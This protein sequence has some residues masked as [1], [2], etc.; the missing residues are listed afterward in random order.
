MKI[1]NL[2]SIAFK[3]LKEDDPLIFFCRVGRFL[4]YQC[5][6]YL[7]YFLSWKLLRL[8]LKNRYIEK[9]IMG[10][11]MFLD[12]K[13]DMG[14]SYDLFRIGFREPF[15]TKAFHEE[16]SRGDVVVDIGA[17]IGY[18]VLLEA[19][20]VGKEGRVYAI[21]PVPQN[22]DLLKK[23]IKLN[24][25]SNVEVFQLAIGNENKKDL[26][27]L[28]SK[29]NCG[30]MIK[31]AVMSTYKDEMLVKVVSLDKF[32][33]N[34]PFPDLIR[35]DVEGYEIKIIRGMKKILES[36]KPLKIFVEIHPNIMK[37]KTKDFL[38][39]LKNFGFQAKKSNP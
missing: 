15:A 29:R 8:R 3:R 16:L 18:Y 12:V 14:I 39:I 32:L 38:N 23:N 13:E 2:V 27:Y 4:I 28:S 1:R 19:M 31:K 7:K 33:E 9:E 24:N 25:Y 36:N 34:K 11:R 26:I 22:V 17:N 37:G 20:L 21:E 30:S 5:I 6:L 35:M 10:N